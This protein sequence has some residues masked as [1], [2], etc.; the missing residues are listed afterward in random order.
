MKANTQAAKALGAAAF[1]RGADRAP[2]FDADMM[3][4]TMGREIGDPRTIAE[5]KAWHAG[6]TQAMLAE[7][8]A[9]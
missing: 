6:W 2:I 9:A 3:K 8:V 5:L 7:E 4:V 1:A